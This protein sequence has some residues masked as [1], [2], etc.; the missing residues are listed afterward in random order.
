[1]TSCFATPPEEIALEEDKYGFHLPE[2]LDNLWKTF[3]KF[4]FR[5]LLSFLLYLYRIPQSLRATPSL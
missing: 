3:E 2:G 4:Y 5:S 1:M